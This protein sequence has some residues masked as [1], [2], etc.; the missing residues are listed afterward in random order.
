M[1]S[2]CVYL[3][4]CNMRAF[5]PHP[6]IL[7]SCTVTARQN[8]GVHKKDLRWD[9]EE[10]GLFLVCPPGPDLHSSPNLPL[11][12]QKKTSENICSNSTEAQ[13]GQR[14]CAGHRE[15]WSRSS[16]SPYRPPTNYRNAKEGPSVHHDLGTQREIPG[17]A[18]APGSLLEMPIS[19]WGL[20]TV[21]PTDRQISK[22]KVPLSQGQ[23]G[24]AEA[25]GGQKAESLPGRCLLHPQAQAT[26][27]FQEAHPH[28]PQ[29]QMP[30]SPCRDQDHT[31]A[32]WTVC[33]GSLFW[34]WPPCSL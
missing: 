25:P 33:S 4:S 30:T 5:L 28:R 8:L 1:V 11:Q 7:A 16:H 6:A 20:K 10:Q 26:T 32:A 14:E 2:T 13:T 15:M 29:V 12:S 27:A 21:M 24:L 3:Q 9:M 17:P 18:A 19:A 34:S 23:R 31:Q 22:R